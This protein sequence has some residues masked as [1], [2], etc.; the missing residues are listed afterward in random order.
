MQAITLTSTIQ[1]AVRARLRQYEVRAL[2][3]AQERTAQELE[4]LVIARTRELEKTNDELRREMGER[5]RIEAALRQAQK[6]DA[7]G[8]LSGGIAHDFNN[9]LQGWPGVST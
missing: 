1:A 9:L 6:M 4:A 3:E 8:Q 5:A 2:L 7:V